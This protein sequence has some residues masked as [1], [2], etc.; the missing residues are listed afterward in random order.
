LAAEQRAQRRK[1]DTSSIVAWNFVGGLASS[2]VVRTFVGGYPE[3]LSDK[4]A[5][6]CLF[7]SGR[8]N[9]RLDTINAG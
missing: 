8:T 3:N 2:V 4:R 6:V 5:N 1:Y 9:K 7:H